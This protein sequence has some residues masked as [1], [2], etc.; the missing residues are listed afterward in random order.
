MALLKYRPTPLGWAFLAGVAGI[1]A[2]IAFAFSGGSDSK[3]SP[4]AQ[5]SASPTEDARLLLG[6][7]P[8]ATPTIVANT[9]PSANST[10][11]ATATPP[12]GDGAI[13]EAN[14]PQP[15]VPGFVFNFPLQTWLSIGDRY[16][17]PRGTGYIHGGIDLNVDPSAATTLYAVCNGSFIGGGK[18]SNY[19]TYFVID[20]GNQWT[21]VYAMV[22]ST[23]LRVGDAVTTGQAV[24]VVGPVQDTAQAHLHFEIRYRGYPI[25][26]E[27]Y[28]EFGPTSGV[29]P[30]PTPGPTQVPTAANT[31]APPATATPGSDNGGN[32]TQPPAPTDTPQPAPTAT[33]TP[34][35]PTATPTDTPIPTQT[36]APTRTP[37]PRR[38]PTPAPV[39]D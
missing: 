39:S 8:T 24:G 37:L 21:A 33:P 29:L 19:G 30:T 12:P 1:I 7:G 10:V 17:A 4:G 28:M 16:G 20:C 3:A 23:S 22:A 35:Q 9:T 18:S 32:A 11:S 13:Q 5:V 26:P 15:P 14:P 38:S 36:V 27:A 25:N 2:A 34:W 6:D 31:P